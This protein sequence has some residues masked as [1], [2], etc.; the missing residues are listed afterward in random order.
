MARQKDPNEAAKSLADHIIKSSQDIKKKYDRVVLTPQRLGG[1][2]GGRARWEQMTPE[3]RRAHIV[4][5]NKAKKN[6]K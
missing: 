5:M 1:L 2:R 4:K 6:S 3:E